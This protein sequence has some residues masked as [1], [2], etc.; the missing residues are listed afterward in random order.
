M[1]PKELLDTFLQMLC[2]PLMGYLHKILRY[3]F[4]IVIRYISGYYP[5]WSNLFC[6]FHFRMSVY[7]K[8]S[9]IKSQYGDLRQYIFIVFT[10]KLQGAP[11][12]SKHSENRAKVAPECHCNQL[13]ICYEK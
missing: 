1:P 7:L 2:I 10:K 5:V 3:A 6:L 4:F 13:I 12:S 8:R 9:G 11:Y